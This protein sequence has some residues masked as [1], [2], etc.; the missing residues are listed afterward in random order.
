MAARGKDE[1]PEQY[2]HEVTPRAILLNSRAKPVT[3]KAT[4]MTTSARKG[5]FGGRSVSEKREVF[6]PSNRLIPCE[7]VFAVDSAGKNA[8]IIARVTKDFV[9][10]GHLIVP[11]NT[12]V[13]G[14]VG[15]A[16]YET[17][18][19]GRVM[20]TGYWRL[21]LPAQPGRKKGREILVHGQALTRRELVVEP[22]GRVRQWAKDEDGRPGLYGYTVNTRAAPE[23]QQVALDVLR[24][25]VDRVATTQKDRETVSSPLS[26]AQMTDAPTMRNLGVD[27]ASGAVAGLLDAK[28]ARIAD[29]I[30]RASTY[31]RV[32]GGVPFY[33]LV[34]DP[35]LPDFAVSGSE[36][37]QQPA[38][39]K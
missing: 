10:D 34:E 27:S 32:N 11:E 4:T 28:S 37:L 31:V 38:S 9:Y 29:E 23:A 13:F 39:S 2:F 8:P 35:L 22:S 16:H 24:G 6:A 17:E 33:L 30:K 3:T 15:A 14:H 36:V 20:D 19:V 21:I 1:A 26:G 18:N 7:L 5:V 12:E 25:V